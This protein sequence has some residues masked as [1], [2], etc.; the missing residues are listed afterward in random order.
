MVLFRVGL[1]LINTAHG[2]PRILKDFPREM[3][4]AII[5]GGTIGANTQLQIHSKVTWITKIFQYSKHYSYDT[6][7]PGMIFYVY[8][9]H[10]IGKER[11]K[12]KSIPVFSALKQGYHIGMKYCPPTPHIKSWKMWSTSSYLHHILAITQ[13]SEWFE[14]EITEEEANPGEFFSSMTN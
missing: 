8:N 6:T 3:S 13:M 1:F 12:P 2:F 5:T 14:E 10:P 4:A 9:A 11:W 7:K